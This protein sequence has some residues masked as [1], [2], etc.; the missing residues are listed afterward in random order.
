[1]YKAMYP[2]GLCPPKCY[3][4]PKIH[5]TGIPIRPIVS[6]MGSVTY[7]VAKVLAKLLKPL[8]GKFPSTTYKVPGTLLTGLKG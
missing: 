5:K 8:V 1:M 6:S 4:F 3:G 2:T 7:G